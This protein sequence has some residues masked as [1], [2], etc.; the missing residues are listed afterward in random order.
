VEKHNLWADLRT[1]L[2]HVGGR[3][4]VGYLT[5]AEVLQAKRNR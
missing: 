2:R 4:G 5:N 1:L 3:Q